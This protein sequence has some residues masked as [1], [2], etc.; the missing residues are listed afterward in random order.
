MFSI[1]FPGRSRSSLYPFM[2]RTASG[3]LLNGILNIY[4][5]QGFT[6]HDVVAKLRGIL[7]TRKIGHT[8]TLDPM[9]EGVLPVC[10]GNA[11][12]LCELLTDTGKE[13]ET[14]LL[15]GLTTDTQD[16]TGTVTAKASETLV[17]SL[18]EEAVRTAVKS[19]VGAYDQLPPMYS[20]I[21]KNGKRL[22]ELA[23]EGKTVNRERRRV[24]IESIEIL[25]ASLPRMKLRVSCSKGTY[26]RTL[27]QDIGDY[28]GVGATMTSLLRTRVDQF[29]LRSAKRISEIE[30]CAAAG[31]P[32]RFLIP[33]ES[34]FSSLRQI[35]SGDA[36]KN[37]ALY[38]KLVRNGNVIPLSLFKEGALHPEREERFRVYDPDGCFAGIYF[39]D[40]AGGLLK[41]YK[42][43][44]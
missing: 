31:E 14:E 41:P 8:G 34:F 37:G 44:R 2:S 1:I 35:A 13:Y 29:E 22:Y 9:A 39:V 28:L 32:D 20:A 6:S 36:V 30:L 38:E 7:K 12:K 40:E 19:F 43:F 21:K 16:I 17:K 33:T 42:L 5:E 15:F 24:Y 26:I 11:T 18:T 27:C 3:I 4:K 10:I 25:S 23:R